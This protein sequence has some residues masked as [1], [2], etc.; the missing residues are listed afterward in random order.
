MACARQA[1][2]LA[3]SSD[4][5]CAQRDAAVR[6]RLRQP[7]LRRRTGCV[8]ALLWECV[9]QKKKPVRRGWRRCLALDGPGATVLNGQIVSAIRC[10]KSAGGSHPPATKSPARQSSE[11]V[12]TMIFCKRPSAAEP[13]AAQQSPV[14]GIL[15]QLRRRG[16]RRS[17]LLPPARPETSDLPCLPVVQRRQLSP[18]S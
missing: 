18:S 14:Q 7:H 4:H 9:P 15:L 13:Q 2:Q 12:P 8:K 1:C 6:L 10:G 16:W 3:R 11:P 17:T 5:L